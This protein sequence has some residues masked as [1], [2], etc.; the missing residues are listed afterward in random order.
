MWKLV[1]SEERNLNLKH[2]IALNI[3]FLSVRKTMQI[4]LP[5]FNLKVDQQ[6]REKSRKKKIQ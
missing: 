2:K 4:V 3:K 6:K 1:V 5:H